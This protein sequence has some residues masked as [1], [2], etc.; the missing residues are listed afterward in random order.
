MQGLCLRLM[1]DLDK[2]ILS[3]WPIILK[4]YLW[5]STNVDNTEV[6]IV[7]MTICIIFITGT[8]K[9]LLSVPLTL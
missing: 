8:V 9:T 4:F 6:E 2:P 5:E 3:D 1:D 7:G